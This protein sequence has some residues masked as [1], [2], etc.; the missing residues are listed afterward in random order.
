M[1][2]GFQ[3]F[4]TRIIWL[5]LGVPRRL[6][7][8]KATH[9]FGSAPGRIETM[10]S[11]T[12]LIRVISEI[13]EKVVR[14]IT[15]NDARLILVKLF[16][17][18]DETYR[19]Y[20]RE[21]KDRSQLAKLGVSDASIVD[22]FTKNRNISRN[23]IDAV[24]IWIENCVLHQV[25]DPTLKPTKEF[26]LDYDLIID[27][28]FYGLASQTLS[29]LALTEKNPTTGFD[30]VDLLI[31]D[32]IV[33]QIHKEHPMIY[34]NPLISGNQHIL[35]S[36]PNLANIDSTS[37]G[38]GF[39]SV[40]GMDFGLFLGVL[41]YFQ[42]CILSDGRH[43]LRTLSKEKFKAEVSNATTP[44]CDPE[45]FIR[46]FVLTQQSI[47]TQLKQDEPLI[48]VMGVN[49]IRLELL[50]FV[51]LSNGD[52]LISYCALDQAKQLWGSLSINGGMCY[53]NEKDDLTKAFEQKNNELSKRLVQLI[54]DKLQTHYIA[55]FDKIDVAYDRIFGEKPDN[56]GDYD[57]VFYTKQSNELFLIEAKYFSDSLTSSGLV[58]DFT[59][60]FGKGRYYDHCRG[61]YD[62]ALAEPEKLKAFV[63]SDQTVDVHF[64]FVTSKPLEVEIQDADGV[65][66]FLSLSVFDNYLEGKLINSD[67]DN[68][69]RPTRRI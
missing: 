52:V 6:L 30:G 44:P 8:D 45:L 60:L 26:E 21:K 9:Y 66:T 36:N 39:R 19:L 1:D 49:K 62:L 18:L 35:D 10:Q 5:E 55:N 43:P 54:R 61:R 23:I 58:T 47:K 17:I 31:E 22:T 64:L 34:F 4:S 33:A 32:D 2:G 48:W 14:K 69:V 3:V 38:I 51:M 53:T 56:Y 42:R 20:L 63:S 67:N 13:Q 27:M 50:P 11:K 68:V 16:K 24:Y 65:V 28:Y 57:L 41:V 40:Y 7:H 12:I 25:I 15:E 46:H 59:K 37:F 29:L